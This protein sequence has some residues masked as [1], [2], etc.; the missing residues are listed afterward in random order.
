MNIWRMLL[1]III[2]LHGLVHLMGLVSYLKLGEVQGLPYKTTV[3]D[4]RINLG[5]NGIGIYGGLWGVATLGFVFAAIGLLLNS[6]W[7]LPLLTTTAV[8]SLILTMVD[9][10]VAMAGVVVNVAL[11]IL[12]W[13]AP[14]LPENI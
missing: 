6:S 7:W 4:G 14:R 2:V 10:N 1:A 8:F 9:L 5:N 3:L 12:A 11:L 13:V